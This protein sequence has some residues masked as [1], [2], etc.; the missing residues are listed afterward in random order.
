[1]EASSVPGVT[2][3]HTISEA[4]VSR[5]LKT[6]STIFT[7]RSNCFHNNFYLEKQKL[8][9]QFMLRQQE[10]MPHT[11]HGS[12]QYHCASLART[13]AELQKHQLGSGHASHKDCMLPP[14]EP[15]ATVAMPMAT[16][17]NNNLISPKEKTAR[18][19]QFAKPW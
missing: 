10:A 16:T 15:T 9:R 12:R 3:I 17:T 13:Q 18:L 5:E 1:M 19:E 2:T 6:S 14:H 4:K 11:L 8:P 7:V